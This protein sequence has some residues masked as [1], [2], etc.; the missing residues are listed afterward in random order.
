MLVRNFRRLPSRGCIE[1]RSLIM[2][3]V[4][5]SPKARTLQ[6]RPYKSHI[7]VIGFQFW[8]LVLP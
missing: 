4:D 1:L 6:G 3:L 7:I 2:D 5:P 8:G